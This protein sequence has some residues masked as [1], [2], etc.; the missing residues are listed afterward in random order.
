M[1]GKFLIINCTILIHVEWY[2]V[3]TMYGQGKSVKILIAIAK[4][5]PTMESSRVHNIPIIKCI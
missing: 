2:I 3:L 5:K 4:Y 1:S